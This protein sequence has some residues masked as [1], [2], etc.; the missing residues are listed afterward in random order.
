MTFSVLFLQ[1]KQQL[2]KFQ[3]FLLELYAKDSNFELH[4]FVLVIYGTMLV[5]IHV[6]IEATRLKLFQ[7]F[8]LMRPWKPFLGGLL[9]GVLNSKCKWTF[10]CFL[11]ML[12]ST[13]KSIFNAIYSYQ[14]YKPT[15]SMTSL[16]VTL[17]ENFNPIQNGHF[18]G[19]SWWGEGEKRTLTPKIFH[20][21]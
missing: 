15:I 6:K 7:C 20:M 14:K 12:V 3:S 10:S 21:Y 13:S 4:M 2:N 8:W 17:F 9:Q 19:C 5:L 1:N 18:R 11:R 16:A